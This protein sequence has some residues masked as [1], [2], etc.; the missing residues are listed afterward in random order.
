MRQTISIISRKSHRWL[1]NKI[2]LN[3]TKMMHSQYQLERSYNIAEQFKDN[4]SRIIF[5]GTHFKRL[6]Q[7]SATFEK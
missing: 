4:M 5:E 2:I 7:Q 3:V 6:S 1:I